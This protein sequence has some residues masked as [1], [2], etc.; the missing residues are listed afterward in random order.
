VWE[1][2]VN[3]S[4]CEGP[5]LRGYHPRKIFE[6][7]DVKSCILVTACCE[8]FLLFENYGQEV[9]GNNTLLAVRL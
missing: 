9:G 5:G 4:R 2:V 1:G 8:F 7:S 3:P 6:N